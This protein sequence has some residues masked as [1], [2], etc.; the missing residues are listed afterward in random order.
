MRRGR[1]TGL[2]SQSEKNNAEEGDLHAF[3]C[4][5]SD[6]PQAREVHC[7]PKRNGSPFDNSRWGQHH[8]RGGWRGDPTNS[9]LRE[10]PLLSQ[11]LT[12]PSFTSKTRQLG[13]TSRRDPI[14]TLPG[15][16]GLILPEAEALPLR[17][18]PIATTAVPNKPEEQ[19][20]VTSENTRLLLGPQHQTASQSL[21]TKRR[22][23][24]SQV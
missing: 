17:E 6:S 19:N 3:S 2:E 16:G 18:G 24:A 5:S 8:P 14:A 1:H 9:K 12:L 4:R 13:N 23:I 21:G 7:L 20:N 22:T 15:Q 10:R 11:S